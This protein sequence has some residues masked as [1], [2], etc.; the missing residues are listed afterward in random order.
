MT[1]FSE[2]F[3]RDGGVEDAIAKLESERVKLGEMWSDGRTTVRAK[4]QALEMT[5]DGRGELIDLVFDESKYRTLV[6]KQLARVILDTL[7]LGRLRTMEKLIEV[8]SPE[9]A[10][11]DLGTSAYGDGDPQNTLDALIPPLTQR[12]EH[13]GPA[14]SRPCRESEK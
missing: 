1:D 10:G 14:A 5:F 2:I 4:N 13:L 3:D 11:F 9:S 12:V 7:Q 8:M 6:P